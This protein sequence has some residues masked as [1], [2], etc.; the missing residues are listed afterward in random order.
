MIGAMWRV[1][2]PTCLGPHPL[3]AKMQVVIAVSDDFLMAAGNDSYWMTA[4]EGDFTHDPFNACQVPRDLSAPAVSLVQAA[5]ML[6]G[7]ELFGGCELQFAR[8]LSLSSMGRAW[9][10]HGPSLVGSTAPPTSSQASCSAADLAGVLHAFPACL[11]LCASPHAG[12][13]PAAG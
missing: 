8:G 3:L 4:C 10:V 1:H 6:P 12:T 9:A 5:V 7:R 11:R 13:H 2:T